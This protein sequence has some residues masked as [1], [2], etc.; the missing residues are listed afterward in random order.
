MIDSGQFVRD[1]FVR[2]DA[3]FSRDLAE[4]CVGLLWEQLD[5]TRD[6]PTTWTSPVVRLGYQQAEP[7]ARAANT[8]RLHAAYD[9]LVGAGRWMPRRD[10]G[11]FAIRFPS[12][13]SP[14]DDGWHV[15]GSFPPMARDG[16]DDSFAWR[17][18]LASRGRALLMLFLFSDTTD[19]DA[20]TRLRVGSHH[21]VARILAPHGD[22]GLTMMEVSGHGADASSERR[23]EFALG[24]AGDVYLC[25][26]FLVHAAQAHHGSAARGPRFLAQPPLPLTGWI[27]ASFDVVAGQSP[28][29][30]ALREAL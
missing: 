6:D 7:F 30:Q 16:P 2:I 13:R 10:L 12:E 20:P 5:E 28:V 26:P 15:D 11:T 27:N 1:G 29:E 18:N 17:V 3:A 19:E 22:D 24:A 25:H 8:Q 14:G 4:E 9:A 21:D 23:V